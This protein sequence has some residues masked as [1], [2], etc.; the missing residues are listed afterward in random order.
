VAIDSTTSSVYWSNLGNSTIGYASLD[1]SGGGQLPAPGL[2][3]PRGL[4]IDPAEGR[5]YV[6]NAASNAITFAS[7]DGS[8]G[9]GQLLTS[10][11]ISFL[12][13][14]KAPLGTGAPEITGG[15][16]VDQELSCGEGDWAPDLIGAFLY[17]APRSF[18][19][20][21]RL[22][23][24]VISG[25]TQ[26]TFTPTTPGE[27]SCRVT[28][29]NESGSTSQTSA[30]RTV[31]LDPQPPTPVSPEVEITRVQR[32]RAE[33]TAT[34]TVAT[35]LSGSLR[36]QKTKKVKAGGPVELSEAGSAKLRV[37]PRSRAAGTLRRAG[38]VEVNPKILFAATGGR[39]IGIRHKFSLR[40][41]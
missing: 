17:R 21:W 6:A 16:K 29:T 11:D 34:L 26:P 28:A 18:A 15:G 8:G 39:E 22:G 25:A 40:R 32:N 37:I 13:L 38:R 7:L 20:Q 4:A 3:N 12:I 5:I 24:N 36:I 23:G 1:G 2:S 9:G 31:S 41:R 19:H 27:Y 35:N 33:G 10:P 30:L 14:L